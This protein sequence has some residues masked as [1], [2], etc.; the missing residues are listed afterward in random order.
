MSDRELARG[1]VEACREKAVRKFNEW[2]DRDVNSCS[3]DSD[4]IRKLLDRMALIT[5]AAKR[6]EDNFKPAGASEDNYLSRGHDKADESYLRCMLKGNIEAVAMMELIE[7][8]LRTFSPDTINGSAS[9]VEVFSRQCD[10]SRALL[11]RGIQVFRKNGLL[12]ADIRIVPV[13]DQLT[14]KMC[15][16]M[17]AMFFVKD[18]F[19]C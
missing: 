8:K 12:D 1:E 4:K 14:H 5:D 3:N 17:G 15:A 13:K 9:L 2:M 11:D 6:L 18:A 19:P 16:L 7:A 10:E